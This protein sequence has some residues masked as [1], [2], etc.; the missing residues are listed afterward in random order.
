[1]SMAAKSQKGKE[2]EGGGEA[3]A[4]E[5]EGGGGKKKASFTDSSEIKGLPTAA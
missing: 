4:L 3:A 1:M 5:A 2:A